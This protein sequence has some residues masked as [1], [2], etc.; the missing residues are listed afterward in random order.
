[1]IRTGEISILLI[2][3]MVSVTTTTAESG[4]VVTSVYSSTQAPNLLDLS[5][6]SF[7]QS[8]KEGIQPSRWDSRLSSAP[9]LSSLL[10][11]SY[12]WGS[13]W[14]Y[15]SILT[16]NFL[17]G[18]DVIFHLSGT[19]QTASGISSGPFGEVSVITW[20]FKAIQHYPTVS[21]TCHDQMS[22]ATFL[23]EDKNGLCSE[24]CD[25]LNPGPLWHEPQHR[26]QSWSRS[27]VRHDQGHRSAEYKGAMT[28]YHEGRSR[29]VSWTPS[30]SSL[31]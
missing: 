23:D 25:Y 8:S 27:G 26:I 10:C 28:S 19:E 20:L 30:H 18:K 3:M 29:V 2:V 17:P 15:L 14:R 12:Q 9:P 22:L 13:K 4:L 1:M 5:G 16:N 6:L 11:F 24:S 7:C 31:S 21:C